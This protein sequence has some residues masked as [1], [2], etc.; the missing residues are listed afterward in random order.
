MATTL[1]PRRRP[2]PSTTDT[3]PTQRE[4]HS[5]QREPVVL[6]DAL[7]DVMTALT[8]VDPDLALVHGGE[9]APGPQPG[10]IPSG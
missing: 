4:P 1:D 7:G 3:Y 9:T 5:T 2:R 8:A 10:T 6:S